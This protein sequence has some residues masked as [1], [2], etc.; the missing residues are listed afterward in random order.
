MRK[1][2]LLMYLLKLKNIINQKIKSG[3]TKQNNF[4]LMIIYKYGHKIICTFVDS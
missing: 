3:E 2:N 4:D 1:A